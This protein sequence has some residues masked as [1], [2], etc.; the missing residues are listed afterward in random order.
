MNDSKVTLVVS[1]PRAALSV[2]TRSSMLIS[3]TSSF[4]FFIS[5]G[6][7]YPVFEW[8]NE[9]KNMKEAKKKKTHD[10]NSTKTYSKR[11]Q[12]EQKKTYNKWINTNLEGERVDTCMHRHH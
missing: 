1:A 5:L 12:N 4:F 10:K 2:S 3:A 8:M 7:T 6:N 11:A 9:K